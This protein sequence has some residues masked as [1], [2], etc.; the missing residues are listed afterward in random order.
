[1]RSIYHAIGKQGATSKRISLRSDSLF[2]MVAAMR[3]HSLKS[4]TESLFDHNLI[5]YRQL[6]PAKNDKRFLN[7][8]E[9]IGAM[10]KETHEPS[11]SKLTGY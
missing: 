7:R 3:I 8:G 9:A 2:G 11:Q 1:M 10:P 6:K 5:Y 4:A